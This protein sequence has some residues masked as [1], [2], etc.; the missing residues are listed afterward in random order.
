MPSGPSRSERTSGDVERHVM[1]TSAPRTASA[2]V[3]ACVALC[4]DANAVARS[5]VRFQTVS[6]N[7][8]AATLV[9]GAGTG[10][11]RT[12]TI[13]PGFY[14]SPTT[15]VSNGVAIRP[16]AP[17]SSAISAAVTTF[18]PQSTATATVNVTP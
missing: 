2:G 8:A 15:V 18:V 12:A 4:S 9:N 10:A 14:Y 6:G 17:G 11:T 1:T 7:P 5:A 13:N 16:V 3:A